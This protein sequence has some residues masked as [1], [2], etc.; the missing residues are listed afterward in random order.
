MPDR[1]QKSIRHMLNHA[2]E[3]FAL[4]DSHSRADLD[5][6]R[7]FALQLTRLM[8]IVGEASRRVPEQFRLKY[9]ETDW[10][11]FA[12]LRDVLIHKFDA[13]EHETLWNI[14]QEELPRLINQ[15]ADILERET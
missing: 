14:V 7:A 5:A 10:R 8:E 4:A 13:I 15:L 12:G 9:P 6:D 2:R 1:I 11:G 3:A